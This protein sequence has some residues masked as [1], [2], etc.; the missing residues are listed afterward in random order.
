MAEQKGQL[1]LVQAAAILRSQGVP[2]QLVLVGDGPMRNEIE[3]VVK[4]NNLHEHVVITGWMSN[5]QVREQILASR[6]MVLPSFAEGLPVVIMEALALKRPVIS[7]YV[8]GIPEL[9]EAGNCGYLVPAGSVTEL[10]GT[11]RQVL[12]A[13]V[14]RLRELGTR[15]RQRVLERHDACNEA[16]KLS[17]LIMSIAQEQD[18]AI[19]RSFVASPMDTSASG[20]GPTEVKVG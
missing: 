6:A 14:P 16:Q 7:T 1:L 2:F 18:R 17:S 9:V 20:V 12:S 15:G 11:L 19:N 3:T 10:A 8:A 13:D 4:R 5:Q